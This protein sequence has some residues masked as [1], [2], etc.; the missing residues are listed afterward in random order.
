MDITIQFCVAFCVGLFGGIAVDQWLH[1]SPW[2][3]MIGGAIGLILSVGVIVQCIIREKAR[4]ANA[5]PIVI[6]PRPGRRKPDNK[7]NDTP[8]GALLTIDDLHPNHDPHP[9]DDDPDLND[10][11]LDAHDN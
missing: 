7:P 3:V 8:G 11:W 10:T 4:L 2:G 6:K 5:D 9:A 1:T